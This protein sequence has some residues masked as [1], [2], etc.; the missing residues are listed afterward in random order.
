[1][2]SDTV[3]GETTTGQAGTSACSCCGEERHESEL[4]RLGCHSEVALCDGC[5]DWLR[6][7]R[8]AAGGSQVRRAVPILATSDV[9][10]ALEHYRRPRVR[11]RGVGRGRVRVPD[12]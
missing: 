10:R 8:S 4:A 2:T 12:P 1:M 3:T 7:Q 9:T 11:D 6:D 5:L